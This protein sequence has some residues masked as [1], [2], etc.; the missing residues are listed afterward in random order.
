MD[1]SS[2]LVEK[3]N[4]TS[5]CNSIHICARVLYAAQGALGER[6]G[7]G[8]SCHLLRGPCCHKGFGGSA[9]AFWGMRGE[10]A[11]PELRAATDTYVYKHI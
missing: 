5:F 7:F 9:E 2:G 8:S 10:K 1:Y 6:A 3:V 4:I 11:L